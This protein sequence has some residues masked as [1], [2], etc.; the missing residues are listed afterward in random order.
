ML[1]ISDYDPKHSPFSPK[2]LH[3][4]LQW[5]SKVD[6]QVC[7]SLNLTSANHLSV[8]ILQ[9]TGTLFDFKDCFTEEVVVM[10]KM[11]EEQRPAV[12]QS[13]SCCKRRFKKM[14]IFCPQYSLAV[15]TAQLVTWQWFLI[16][17]SSEHCR[18]DV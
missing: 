15:W 10:E 4:A 6:K 8:S 7:I 13:K 2:F 12:T 11:A 1:I 18:A 5:M 9:Q 16:S 14:I 3:N 17:A